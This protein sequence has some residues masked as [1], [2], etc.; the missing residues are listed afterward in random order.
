LT[1]AKKVFLIAT[2]VK[3]AAVIEKAAQ[4]KISNQF[5]ASIIQQHSAGSILVDE[6]A[7]SLLERS[8]S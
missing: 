1:N 5:P 2:G 7:G 6:E 3:K 8:K 4:E